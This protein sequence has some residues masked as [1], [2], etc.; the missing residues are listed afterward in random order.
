METMEL[1][2]DIRSALDEKVFVHVATLNPDG[3]PQV[4]VV[5]MT[6]RR[7]T[8][9]FST[10]QGRVKPRNIANDPRVALSF[11]PPDDTSKNIVMQGRVT[12]IAT[13][14]TWLI[15]ELANKYLGHDSYQFAKPGE[16]RVNYEI[17]IDSISTWG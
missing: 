11:S 3:S 5:W 1:P 16:V 15:D 2:D 9:L 14:G 4:S 7:D 8:V 6:R 12:K 17:E 13:D 10:A